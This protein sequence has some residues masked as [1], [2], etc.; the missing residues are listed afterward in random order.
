MPFSGWELPGSFDL[1]Q[2]VLQSRHGAGGK[3]EYIQVLQLLRDFTIAQ[4]NQ[5]IEK[6]FRYRCLNF[7]AIKMLL[8]SGDDDATEIVRL[9][10]EHLERLPRI[11]I[12]NGDTRQYRM[13]LAGGAS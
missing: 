10:G 1:L 3:R 4:V 2:R 12:D 5:A 9:S 13:L 6:A 7:E 11:R 8:V